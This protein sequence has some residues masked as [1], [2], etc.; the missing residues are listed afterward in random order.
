[1]ALSPPLRTATGVAIGLLVLGAAGFAAQRVGWVHLGSVR[2]P[3]GEDASADAAGFAL[4]FAEF[5]ESLTRELSAQATTRGAS[6]LADTDWPAAWYQAR[7]LGLAP[8]PPEMLDGLESGNAKQK[9][10]FRELV[11][12][13]LVPYVVSHVKDA[14]HASLSESARKATN[15]RPEPFVLP[16]EPGA[17]AES[18]VVGALVPQLDARLAALGAASPSVTVTP[19]DP[20]LAAAA[21]A[22]GA[23]STVAGIQMLAAYKEAFAPFAPPAPSPAPFP[24]SLPPAAAGPEGPPNVII[25]DIDTLSADRMDAKYGDEWVLPTLHGLADRGVR[26]DQMISQAGWTVPALVSLLTG[27]YPLAID[28][29]Q[30]STALRESDARTLPEIFGFYGYASTAFWS[31]GV[32]ELLHGASGGFGKDIVRTELVGNDVA[33]LKPWEDWIATAP[34]QPFLLLVHDYDLQLPGDRIL[35]AE[36]HHFGGEGLPC[37]PG[38]YDDT[39]FTFRD[40]LGVDRA[41]SH[42]LRHYDGAAHAYDQLLGQLL[43]KLE[44]AGLMKNTIVVATSNHGQDF[45]THSDGITHGSMFD[46][47]LQVP[48]VI[49]GPGVTA[50]GKVVH[51]LVQTVDVAPTVLELAHIRPEARMAGHS[52]VPL[53]QGAE[54]G[55]EYADRPAFSLTNERTMAVRTPSRK[56][57]LQDWSDTRIALARREIKKPYNDWRFN[58]YDLKTDAAEQDDRFATEPER[59]LDLVVALM[60]YRADRSEAASHGSN[61][62][63][64]PAMR[65]I[66]RANGYWNIAGG[67]GEEKSAGP[68]PS[69]EEHRRGVGASKEDP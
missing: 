44:A 43:A 13:T 23:L 17:R 56:L 11:L 65:E 61:V 48:L 33:P 69:R 27:R 29:S 51:A 60:A 41:R 55:P 16:P 18:L 34:K 63:V 21:Q 49:A 12:A 53:L 31:K 8:V 42:T 67:P 32:P 22:S 46:T 25:L 4:E 64:D 26:F 36:E 45:A 30:S 50:K 14:V 10:A 35:A 68:T 40:I 15:L 58:A 24:P 52:L 28:L 2:P 37:F 3:W 5:D 57:M 6:V 47:V 62:T 59:Y 39:L 20:A 7:V 9:A 66:F 54:P 19:P 38:E 1:M